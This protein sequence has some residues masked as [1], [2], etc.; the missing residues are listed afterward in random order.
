MGA[1]GLQPAKGWS[2]SRP[3]ATGE[4]CRVRG[5]C[6][7]NAPREHPPSGDR[8]MLTA[9]LYPAAATPP[10]PAHLPVVSVQKGPGP[11]TYVPVDGDEERVALD[12]LHAVQ[13]STWG[14]REQRASEQRRDCMPSDVTAEP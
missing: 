4:G 7:G 11:A 12:L 13:P 2:D 3:R 6:L 9:G 5:L 1:Q 14:A 8:S 10:A